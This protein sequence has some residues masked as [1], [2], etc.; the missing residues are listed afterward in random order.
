M[1]SFRLWNIWWLNCFFFYVRVETF[2]D[3]T[4]CFEHVRT[5]CTSAIACRLA[6][7]CR[8]SLR[9]GFCA[10]TIRTFQLCCIPTWEMTWASFACETPQ[11][12]TK[13][14][15]DLDGFGSH[16]QPMR[17]RWSSYNRSVWKR[18]TLI[19]SYPTRFFFFFFGGIICSL[20]S[21]KCDY[22][23]WVVF[24]TFFPL[25]LQLEAET[26]KCADESSRLSVLILSRCKCHSAKS[27]HDRRLIC[28][29]LTLYSSCT[30]VNKWNCNGMFNLQYD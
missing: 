10:E 11:G 22:I 8:H 1:R 5:K 6:A 12:K 13:P 28:G 14:G 17:R 15:Q 24:L 23:A 19:N 9:R 4:L 20:A 30:K 16:E 27:T 21:C 29:V 18:G 7:L 25:L 3:S 26:P 2:S